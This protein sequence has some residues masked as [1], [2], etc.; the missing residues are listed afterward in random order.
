M[1]LIP[2]AYR[3]IPDSKY[4][5]AEESSFTVFKNDLSCNRNAALSS[6]KKPFKKI[7]SSKRLFLE[8]NH[9]NRRISLKD[10]AKLFIMKSPFRHGDLDE[11]EMEMEDIPEQPVPKLESLRRLPSLK[12]EY[13]GNVKIEIGCLKQ[14][15]ESSRK[16][17]SLSKTNQLASTANHF[18]SSFTQTIALNFGGNRD[19]Q[20][21]HD[22]SGNEDEEMKS[23]QGD[24]SLGTL[25]NSCKSKK[26]LHVP[27]HK[28]S[29][30][31][32][33]QIRVKNVR[34]YLSL[35]LR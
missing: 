11:A 33:Y 6:S 16:L 26:I 30:E 10:R 29:K 35:Q 34:S 28:A 3:A 2:G 7:A 24:S 32:K 14:E 17:L 25:K 22:N 9:D 31:E 18:G 13:I 1:A 4:A 15:D 27:R 5:S 20:N 21:A 23:E 19:L 12:R 8:A